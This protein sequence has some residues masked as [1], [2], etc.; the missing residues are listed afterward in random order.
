MIITGIIIAIMLLQLI[1]GWLNW[2]NIQ[3][4]KDMPN[5]IVL[6]L[7]FFSQPIPLYWVIL[8]FCIILI[9]LRILYTRKPY[10]NVN[11]SECTDYQFKLQQKYFEKFDKEMP[12]FNILKDEV[13]RNKLISRHPNRNFGTSWQLLEK[14]REVAH[15]IYRSKPKGYYKT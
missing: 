15:K 2:A 12:D 5:I 1:V 6:L 4:P 3:P 11:K 13:T 14:G 7:N 8:L 10:L 9:T